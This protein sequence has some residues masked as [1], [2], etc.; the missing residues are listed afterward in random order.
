MG[1]FKKLLKAV[2]GKKEVPT[3]VTR[4]PQF[5]SETEWS[6]F[7]N[8]K[9]QAENAELKAR[10][11]KKEAKEEAKKK[12][13]EQEYLERQVVKSVLKQREEKK[14][15]DKER[16]L[17]LKFA[18]LP[19]NPTFF[20]KSNRGYGELLGVYL[21]ETEDGSL[22][23]YPWLGHNGKNVRFSIPAGSFQE[24]F[25]ED[26]GLVSQIRGGKVDSNFD[27]TKNG[28][29]VL[30]A[31]M[32][33]ADG[34]EEVRVID[35]TDVERKKYEDQIKEWEDKYYE[36]VHHLKE[37]RKKEADY[38]SDLAEKEMD[39]DLYHKERDIFAG[40]AGL[41]TEKQK[42]GTKQLSEALV[43][44]Q[45][46]KMQQI[47]EKRLGEGVKRAFDIS[48]QKYGEK[49]GMEIWELT[50]A[51]AKR[52]AKEAVY[53]ALR[54]SPAAMPPASPQKKKGKEEEA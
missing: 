5:E 50:S 2:A 51:Q 9:L 34:K 29:A 10:L 47:L 8:K 35:V 27:I 30:K 36:L 44:V 16:A 49:A 15:S 37:A 52:I 32:F 45:D 1:F 23:W 33:I 42:A 43:D 31:P 14:K 11:L 48:M 39:V 25:K 24:W 46:T 38:R 26:I 4:M 41:V 13:R 22:L 53:E 28:K 12:E 20:L 7:I 17:K 40:Q 18:D 6:R 3:Y 54:T 19:K 21:Q